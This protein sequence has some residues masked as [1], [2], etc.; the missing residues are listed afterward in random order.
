MNIEKG[1]INEV[2]ENFKD[3]KVLEDLKNL[4]D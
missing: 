2:L 1:T 4:E 3:R